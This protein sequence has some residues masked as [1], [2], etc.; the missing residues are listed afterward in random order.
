M[1][2]WHAVVGPLI[3]KHPVFNNVGIRK[4][5]IPRFRIKKKTSLTLFIFI[6]YSDNLTIEILLLYFCVCKNF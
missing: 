3:K 1:H 5:Q 4:Y 2:S 6:F